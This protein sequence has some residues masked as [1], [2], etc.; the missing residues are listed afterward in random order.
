M[1]VWPSQKDGLIRPETALFSLV[2]L[3]A[4]NAPAE[5]NTA[6]H[7]PG[8]PFPAEPHVNSPGSISP[9]KAGRPAL[10]ISL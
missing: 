9:N 4:A 6:R 1:Y 8:R 3:E 5:K 10:D 2:Y 7:I